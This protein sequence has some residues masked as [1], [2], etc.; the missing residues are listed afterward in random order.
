MP[1]RCRSATNPVGERSCARL[2]VEVR[3]RFDGALEP[4][5]STIQVTNAAGRR[6]DKGDG[7][8]DERNRRLLRVS[9]GALSP[10]VYRVAWQIMAIDGHRGEGSYTFTVEASG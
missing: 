1:T 10:G 2:P 8:V 6:V 5:F 7:R 3:I 9:L 4:A